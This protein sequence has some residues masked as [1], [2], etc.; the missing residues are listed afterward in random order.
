MEEKSSLTYEEVIK[1]LGDII[2]PSIDKINFTNKIEKMGLLAKL[3]KNEYLILL[4]EALGEKKYYSGG[5]EQTIVDLVD[6]ICGELS[7][8]PIYVSN[9]RGRRLLESLVH[10]PEPYRLKIADA[11]IQSLFVSNPEQ[12]LKLVS[13]T[14]CLTAFKDGKI[15]ENLARKALDLEKYD[16]MLTILQALEDSEEKVDLVI[17]L[18]KKIYDKERIKKSNLLPV[19]NQED[20]AE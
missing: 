10:L 20:K 2:K 11:L 6:F 17:E 1:S 15:L 18:T 5:K 12:A 13:E 3:F 16:A 7:A 4:L 14:E 8:N 9:A 19:N